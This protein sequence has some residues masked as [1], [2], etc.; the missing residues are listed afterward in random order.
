MG[1]LRGYSLGGSIERV[2]VPVRRI[3][4]ELP[5]KVEHWS[6]RDRCPMNRVKQPLKQAVTLVQQGFR[7][8]R[9]VVQ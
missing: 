5:G 9:D 7:V 6:S 8:W 2:F 3:V 1:S 4:D